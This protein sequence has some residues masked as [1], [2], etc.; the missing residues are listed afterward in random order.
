MTRAEHPHLLGLESDGRNR[1]FKWHCYS[2][3]DSGTFPKCQGLRY[4]TSVAPMLDLLTWQMDSPK[5]RSITAP[6]IDESHGCQALC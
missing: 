1:S 4:G 2:Q 6:Q 5:S 3:G